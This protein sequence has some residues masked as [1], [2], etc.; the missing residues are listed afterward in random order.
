[1]SLYDVVI[2]NGNVVLPT[3]VVKT[4]IGVKDGKVAAI[5]KDL[6]DQGEQ[7]WDAEHQYVFPGM[8][9]V[10][11]HFS[12]PG[13][14]H[15]EGFHTGSMMM[16]AGGCTTYF[17]MP[18]NG[19]PS[20]VNK[21]ALD[22]KARI[23]NEK[24]VVDFGLWGG[25]VPGNEEDLKPLAESGVIGFKA[26]LS[27]TGN[28]EFEAVDDITLLDGMKQ[29]A[30]L[31]KVLA[32]HSES[33]SMTNWLKKEKENEGKY[34]A[35]DYLETRPIAAEVEAVERAIYYAELTNC[36][37]HFVH[38]SSAKAMEKIQEAKERGMN[39]TVETCPHYLLFHHG[40][41]RELGAVAKCAPPLRED[42]ERQKLIELLKNDQFD[43]ISSDHSPCPYDLKDP[44]V[45][46]LFEAWG[47]ISGGQFS[48]LAS[49]ELS[50][51]HN[52]PFEKVAKWTAS[53]PA[54]RF[55]ISDRKGH[56]AKGADADFAFVTLDESYTVTAENYYAKHK[57]SLY[58]GHTFPCKVVGTMNRGKLVFKDGEIDKQAD[59]K[60]LKPEN[61]LYV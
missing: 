16:A 7:E 12:E 58:I 11:V 28:K 42:H 3:G 17:D 25:L 40:H 46:N 19:I 35:D 43:M 21:E 24:S 57:E 30:R 2:R 15:W 22:E 61:S 49:I 53:N 18:L 10:H 56:I 39:I 20:T 51:A 29:I 47:G 55:G 13:R 31:G 44:N 6:Q 1:M 8:I 33:A 4:D 45:H 5:E 60:W 52:I 38:I 14:E 36:P 9:D 23:G 34:S 26:F 50:L 48:L 32:L 27:T 37:L 59:R 41:L 54:E